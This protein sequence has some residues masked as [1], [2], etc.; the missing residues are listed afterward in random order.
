MTF[1]PDAAV[2]MMPCNPDEDGKFSMRHARSKILHEKH[3]HGAGQDDS[4]FEIA[5]NTGK[6]NYYDHEKLMSWQSLYLLSCSALTQ[7]PV[8]WMI[9]YVLSVTFS[10]A[11]LTMLI[12]HARK[13]S[14]ERFNLVLTFLKFFLS[15]M[16]GIHVQQSFKR[17]WHCV[18]GFKDYLACIKQMMFLLRAVN[19]DPEMTQTIKRLAVVSSY[20]FNEEVIN[21]QQIKRSRQVWMGKTVDWLVASNLLEDDER[22]K[23][24]QVMAWK[25]KVHAFD[26]MPMSS[27]IWA[28]IGHMLSRARV[29]GVQN[30]PPPLKIRILSSCQE[31]VAKVE[32][33]K[34]V[35]S[36]QI[37]FMY[38][39]LLM[40]LVYV[41]NTLLGITSGLAI[42]SA[43]CEIWARVKQ[44]ED[45]P[46]FIRPGPSSS[47]I[48]VKSRGDIIGEFY[49]AV[50]TA[51][52]HLAIALF[53]PMLYTAFMHIA[54]MLSYPFGDQAYHLPTE[55]F[56]AK[57]HVDLN[58]LDEGRKWSD[59]KYEDL[60]IRSGTPREEL[61]HKHH[62]PKNDKKKNEEDETSSSESGEEGD[63]D[64]GDGD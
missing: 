34:A 38:A 18:K 17:W 22:E 36:A 4:A 53:E 56:I 43:I 19:L 31:C 54:D 44:L 9:M 13:I 14:T 20:I 27:T 59:K 45:N 37:P 63:G 64:M 23:L 58:V 3:K 16:V 8:V 28:W 10:C 52:V 42:G 32:D 26:A 30:I 50:Q 41:N 24:D 60:L 55:S 57:L 21:F 7:L 12:P 47:P 49:E 51:V 6:I 39:Q 35:I 46:D 61:H 48:F 1:L 40:S 2:P 33:V 11:A 5:P 62:P 15:F 25:Y 29:E